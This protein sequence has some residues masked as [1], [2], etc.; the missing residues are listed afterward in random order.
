MS[1]A[2]EQ[3]KSVVSTGSWVF[4]V[5]GILWGSATLVS[6]VKSG[7]AIELYGL[8][9]QLYAG[10]AWVRD[11]IL[12]PVAWP[13]RHYLG[14]AM[15]WWAKDAI[16]AYMTI[17]A[18]FVRSSHA[19]ADATGEAP[20]STFLKVFLWL[21][22][23]QLFYETLDDIFSSAGYVRQIRRSLA[24]GEVLTD[25]QRSILAH[26]KEDTGR[27]WLVVCN[28]VVVLCCASIFFLWN[29]LQNVFG[30]SG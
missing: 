23:P 21:T 16:M 28:L 30:P 29:H 19:Y 3:V 1:G 8:P 20:D 13:L 27:I 2:S 24:R 22:W 26:Y 12:E 9:A 6:F 14:V 15:P 11:M 4:R 17:G 5:L 10:Y 18:A 7:F 25:N